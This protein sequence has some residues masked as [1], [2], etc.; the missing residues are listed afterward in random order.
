MEFVDCLDQVE[1]IFACYDILESKKVKLEASNLRGKAR[2]WWE[3]M[4]IENLRKGK[5]KIHT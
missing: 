5:T 1:E 3:K 4:K 2:S